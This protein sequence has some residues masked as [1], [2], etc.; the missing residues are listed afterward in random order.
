MIVWAD[1]H[2]CVVSLNP[3]TDLALGLTICAV[4]L[5]IRFHEIAHSALMCVV[6]V[7]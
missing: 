2:S 1:H 5:G 7:F 4:I 3:Y 6:A